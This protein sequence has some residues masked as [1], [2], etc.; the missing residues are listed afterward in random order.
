LG[1]ILTIPIFSGFSTT[2]QIVEGKALLKNLE[3]QEESLRQNIRLE[4]EQAFLGLKEAIESITV[5]E[6]S[7]SQAKE[8]YDL[9][10]GRYQVG[11]GQPLEITDAEVLLANARA[12]Y[13]NA[14]YNYKVAEARIDRAMG[15]SR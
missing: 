13:I 8:N 5:T 11:V 6:K 1:A 15:M 4:A 9:A 10:S 7:V 3:A 12:S 14:L 2:N